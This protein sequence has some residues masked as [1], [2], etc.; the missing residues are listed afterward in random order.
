[1]NDIL[2]ILEALDD[3]S[4]NEIFKNLSCHSFFTLLSTAS[5]TQKSRLIDVQ[6]AAYSQLDKSD[7]ESH[8]EDVF[9]TIEEL[10]SENKINISNFVT[11]RKSQGLLALEKFLL[12]N[13]EEL[14]AKQ[15]GMLLLE[16]FSNI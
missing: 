12:L 2:K 1:M 9:I 6:V 3:S 4:I 13:D 11:N 7:V 15:E 16:L 8:V 14:E 5:Q 10:L